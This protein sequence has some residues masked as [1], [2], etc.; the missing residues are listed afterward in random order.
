MRKR[1]LGPEHPDTLTS[2]ANLAGSLSGQG[3]TAEAEQIEREVLAIR[4]RVLGPEHPGTLTTASNLAITLFDQ[5]KYAEA[6]PLF[7]ATLE[8]Q[9]RVLGPD[10]TETLNTAR[11]LDGMRS[12]IRA[13]QPAAAVGNAASGAARPLPAGTRVLVQRLVA[14]PEHNGKGARVVSFDACSR[15]YCVALDDGREIC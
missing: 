2:A 7:E 6:Q 14:K 9:R 15:R 5:R 11:W 1:V 8:V 13:A 10:H 12:H 3:K 4:T